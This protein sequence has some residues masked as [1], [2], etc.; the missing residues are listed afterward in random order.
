MSEVGPRENNAGASSNQDPSFEEVTGFIG[1]IT[2]SIVDA[3]GGSPEPAP[4]QRSYTTTTVQEA[5]N[6][7]PLAIGIGVAALALVLALR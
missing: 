6:Y 1:D 4:D 3:V 2:G 5:P 7:T